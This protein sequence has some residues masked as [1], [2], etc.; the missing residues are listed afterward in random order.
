[1][2]GQFDPSPGLF[3][4]YIFDKV[5]EAGADAI[6]ASHAHVVQRA[7]FRDGRLCAYS[8]GNF[9]MDFRSGLVVP[10]VLPGYGLA[11]NLYLE[12]GKLEKATFCVTC[13][14]VEKGKLVTRPA[15]E[16]MKLLKSEKQRK[17]FAKEVRWVCETVL[18]QSLTGE[19]VREEYELGRIE[20]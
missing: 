17:Q 5:L 16:V 14:R 10:E 18:G 12:K 4:R 9:N 20:A 11:L 13:A 7:G 1:V 2:G 3:T 19:F 6:V 15:T 8:L